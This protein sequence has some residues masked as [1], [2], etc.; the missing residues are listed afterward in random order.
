[1]NPL[2]ENNEDEN[3][4]SEKEQEKKE[5]DANFNVLEADSSIQMM[6]TIK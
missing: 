6:K 3:D 2:S 1:M 4:A 5:N